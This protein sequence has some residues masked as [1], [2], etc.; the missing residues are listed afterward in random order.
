MTL[1]RTEGDSVTGTWSGEANNAN[2][3]HR[4][5]YQ[6]D[7]QYSVDDYF[8]EGWVKRK[9]QSGTANENLAG[10]LLIAGQN[11]SND[12]YCYILDGR[13][14]DSIQIRED[15]DYTS[16]TDGTSSTS[17]N[18]WYF[19]QGYR[20]GSD[21]KATLYS[22]P[23][24]APMSTTTRGSETSYDAG[25]HGLYSYSTANV[26]FDNVR[27]RKRVIPEPTISSY[28]EVENVP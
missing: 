17:V 23:S 24:L 16:R 9:I 22:D 1:I 7:I 28:G 20:D 10:G 26:R 6:N 5:I 12:G 15:A 11:S 19:F 3:A 8:A 13:T 18:V 2:A 27:I 4:V 21:L 25:Y 14:S